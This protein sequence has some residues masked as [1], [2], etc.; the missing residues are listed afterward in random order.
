MTINIRDVNEDGTVTLS[1]RSELRVGD[2]VTATLTDPDIPVTDL[3]WQW[4]RGDADIANAMSA[5]Y[6]AV[7]VMHACL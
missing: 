3:T 2:T 5:S 6:T 7:E 1:S 4:K